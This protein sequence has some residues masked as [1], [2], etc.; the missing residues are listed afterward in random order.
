[1][2]VDRLID[3]RRDPLLA[4]HAAAKLLKSNYARLGTWPLAITAYNHGPAG[5]AKAVKTVGSTDIAR[6][7]SDLGSLQ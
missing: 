4:T 3:E 5:I 7:I 2:R 6:F 1:M